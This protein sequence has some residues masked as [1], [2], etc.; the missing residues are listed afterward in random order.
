[1]T[2][3][4][5]AASQGF[6]WGVERTG[7]AW[8][9]RAYARAGGQDHLGLGS[10]SSDRILPS[11]SPGINVLTI[12]PRYWSV[13]AWI[14]DEFWAHDLPRTRAAF[15]QFYRPREAL[16]AFACQ[17]CKA[18]QHKT[19]VGNI[20]G[21]QRTAG[22]ARE[23][24]EFDPHFNYIKEPLGGF[25]LYYRAT[26]EA[27]GIVQRTDPAGGIPYDTVTPAGR[28]LAL[29]Y[30][31]AVGETE[32]VRHHL[33]TAQVSGLVPREV[34]LEFAHRG[35]LCQLATA[36]HADLPLL[37]DL[38]VH[39]GDLSG[40]RRR[41]LR[42]L[43]DLCNTAQGEGLTRDRF[44]QLIYFRSLDVDVFKPRAETSDA[45]RRWRLYQAR[46]YFGFAINRLWAWMARRGLELSHDGLALV[47]LANIWE[48]LG[49][50]LDANE[51][52]HD[53]EASGL[54]LTSDTTVAA[55][56]TWL[57]D[58]VDITPNADAVWPRHETL[59]E[60]ALYQRCSNTNDDPDTLVAMLA[61]LL[62]VY[63]RIGALER[64]LGVA[65]DRDI[66]AEGGSVR[67]GMERFF[68][69]LR[70]ELKTDP[71]VHDLLAWIYARYVIPQHERVAV[72]KLVNGDTFRFR[73]VG[74]AMQ[75]FKNDAPADFNDSRYIALSTTVHELGLVG[76]L[77]EPNRKLTAAGKTLLDTGDLPAG[78]LQ[79][80]VDQLEAER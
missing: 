54:T 15:I 2:S 21:S 24:L 41:T 30:R 47:P 36:Q 13:Y 79:A 3:S 14:L 62:L 70:N 77:R 19:L 71:S 40:A 58:H 78:A 9:A 45:A 53:R 10:V 17:I 49:T 72:A 59:D 32:L 63:Q 56:L 4:Q 80:A 6:A 31:T 69:A 39:A 64:A 35:C 33:A 61:I 23:L 68:T 51:F 66:V 37:Q 5:A 29:G 1:M 43:L 60:H 16:F 20:V 67:I 46:E 76:T 38:F 57:T 55:F 73:R 75:F 74:T 12:H 52:V 34:L 48:L 18:P 42:F 28:A 50:D 27:M 65:K 26:M 22:P 25:G 7:P 11:L 44:R 8:A